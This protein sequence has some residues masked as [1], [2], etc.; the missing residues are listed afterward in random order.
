MNIV[1]ILELNLD[2]LI[3]GIDEQTTDIAILEILD[4]VAEDNKTLF[5]RICENISDTLK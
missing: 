2:T 5:V 4:T 1:T 3:R